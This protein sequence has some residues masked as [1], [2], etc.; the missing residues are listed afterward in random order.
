MYPEDHTSRWHSGQGLWSSIPPEQWNSWAW[1]LKSQIRTREA[2]VPYLTPTPDEEEGLAFANKKLAFAITPHLFNLIDRE[3]PDCPIRRQVIPQGAERILSPEERIDPLGEEG[4][5]PVP[6]IVHRYPD[7]VLFLVTSSCASYCRYCTRSRLVS[8]AQGYDFRPSFEAGLQYIRDN[9][10]IRDVL[11]SGG[12]PLLLPDRK[13]DE[14]LGALRAIPHVEFIRIGSR[15]PIFMPQRITPELCAVFQR[16]RPLWISLHTN[17]PRECTLELKEACHRLTASGVIMGN[18]SVLLR[19]VNDDAA[20][21]RSLSHRLLQ[22]GVTPHYLFQGDLITGS[23]HLRTPISTG[24]KIIRE[25]RGHTS[26][27]AIP[28]LAIDDPAGGGK[29]PLNP[30]YIRGMTDTEIILENF[31]GRE[32]RYPIAPGAGAPGRLRECQRSGPC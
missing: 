26:S 27:Y 21:I 19:G 23:A 30:D 12:D 4:L 25:L 8:N 31:E 2:L 3:D 7:R 32:V 6:G 16:H 17:H 13:L 9:P 15:I 1:Q 29:I 28:Q 14:L 11:I 18:Q 5:S 24:L 20:T 10:A 22:M